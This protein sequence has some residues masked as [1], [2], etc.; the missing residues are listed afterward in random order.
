VT[1]WPGTFHTGPHSGS[2]ALPLDPVREHGT[3]CRVTAR[4]AVGIQ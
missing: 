1:S 3:P 4:S 2:D